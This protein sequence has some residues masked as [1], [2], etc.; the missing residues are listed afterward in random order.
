[1]PHAALWVVQ[2]LSMRHPT[3]S[4]CSFNAARGFVGGAAFAILSFI[5]IIIV[6]MPHAALWVVQPPEHSAG[7]DCES[8]FNAA[9]GFVG[10]AAS[11]GPRDEITLRF[12]CRTRLCGWCNERGVQN[13][14][15][16]YCFNA[17]RGFV[18]G[19]ASLAK[20]VQSTAREFQCRTRLCGWCN[21][22]C[23][24]YIIAETTP[25]DKCLPMQRGCCTL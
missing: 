14:H 10:G 1:M 4:M 22:L 9:R 13:E 21:V 16:D 18:G 25:N 23:T 11:L 8:G 24:V 20:D 2:R 19:A 17:A 7:H 3:P 5:S 12:Q 15:K 6:S